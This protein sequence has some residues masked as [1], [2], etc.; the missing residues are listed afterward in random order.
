MDF[1]HNDFDIKSLAQLKI[2]NFD[3]LP[4]ESNDLLN[5]RSDI[6]M[7][8][9]DINFNLENLF[10][11]NHSFIDFIKLECKKFETLLTKSCE[12]VMQRLVSM[13]IT[14]TQ[15][16]SI[17]DQMVKSGLLRKDK[18]SVFDF[19]ALKNRD[20]DFFVKKLHSTYFDH[21]FGNLR[22]LIDGFIELTFENDSNNI[23]ISNK[24]S[25][26]VFWTSNQEIELLELMQKN[27]P[28]NLTNREINDFCERHSRTRGAVINKIQKLKKKYADELAKQSEFIIKNMFDGGYQERIVDDKIQ[29]ILMLKGPKTY[30]DILEELNINNTELSRVEIINQTLYDLLSRQ[31]INCK[32]Q[33]HVGLHQRQQTKET[34]VIL[35]KIIEMINLS[36]KE[37]L[38]FDTIKNGLISCF[39]ELDPTKQNFNDDLRDFICESNL[40]ILKQKRVFYI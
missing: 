23:S 14:N 26:K 2:A 5:I 36:G 4:G 28:E 1:E 16:A 31:R 37:D 22:T 30:E 17:K 39:Q 34:S 35:N 27:Y 25:K 11:E 7:N 13:Q 8:Q 20:F 33:I 15:I 21:A 3:E 38:S 12:R 18:I 24:S 19:E 29:D 40:F 32:D 6:L 10:N 9:Q